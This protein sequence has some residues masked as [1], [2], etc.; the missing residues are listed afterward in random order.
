M[1]DSG[2]EKRIQS[3]FEQKKIFLIRKE[4]GKKIFLVSGLTD[5]YTVK[6]DGDFSE[7]SC[8]CFDWKRR[9]RGTGCKHIF[10]VLFRVLK[11]D[12]DAWRD[13]HNIVP[14]DT[15]WDSFLSASSTSKKRKSRSTTECVICIDDFVKG[16]QLSFCNSC[17]NPV[18]SN[19]LSIWISHGDKEA[20]KSC[21]FCRQQ[22]GWD[23][24]Q[25]Q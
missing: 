6:L 18:H 10:F 22:V 19:C 25:Y 12:C 7:Y 4:I 11:I 13:N 21:P 3:A 20:K 1:E 24:G 5:Q 17:E 15:D 2:T 8:T 9:R 16:E 23:T 14:T